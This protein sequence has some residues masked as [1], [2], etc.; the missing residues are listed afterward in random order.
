MPADEADEADVV[1][2]PVAGGVLINYSVVFSADGKF[3]FVVCRDQVKVHSTATI[4]TLTVLQHPAA[5]TGCAVNPLNAF[6][7][8]TT[9]IE[10]VRG[11]SQL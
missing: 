5:V 11:Q 1:E 7:L 9:S 3:F 8:L 6:Q 10:A 4:E 2:G